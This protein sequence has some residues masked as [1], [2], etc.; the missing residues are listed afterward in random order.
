MR[1]KTSRQDICPC[2]PLRLLLSIIALLS[3]MQNLLPPDLPPRRAHSYNVG[4]SVGTYPPLHL[5]YVHGF[6]GDHTSFQRFP[7]DLHDRLDERIPSLQ[8]HV[9]PTYQSKKPLQHAVDRLMD[10][11]ETLEPGYIILI[12]HSLGET[13]QA[14]L[15]TIRVLICPI[16]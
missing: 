9:Y 13:P 10:W 14:S 12:G 11:M 15:Q 16:V 1:T 7:T 4:R 8:T 3:V 5:V 2:S 6:R